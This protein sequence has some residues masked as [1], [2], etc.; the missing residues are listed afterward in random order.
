MIAG[1]FLAGALCMLAAG[2]SSGDARMSALRAD[3]AGRQAAAEL[4]ASRP[5]GMAGDR[6]RARGYA[7]AQ[8]CIDQ[9]QAHSRRVQATS[10]ATRSALAAVSFAGPGGALA[11]RSLAP[12]SGMVLQSQGRYSVACY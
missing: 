11:A 2:C 12:V 8:K 1:R 3:M 10:M 6:E 9:L 4:A 7:S 5:D